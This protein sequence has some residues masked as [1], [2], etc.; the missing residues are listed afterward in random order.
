MTGVPPLLVAGL[1]SVL[2]LMIGSFLNVVA[3][4]VPRLTHRG[5]EPRAGAEVVDEKASMQSLGE[6]APVGQLG[7][8]DLRALQHVHARG[9]YP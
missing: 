4:R 6:L 1:A 2:G 7:L 5:D 3:H 9:P 8:G